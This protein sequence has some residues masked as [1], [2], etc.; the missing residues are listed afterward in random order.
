MRHSCDNRFR[1]LGACG[2]ALQSTPLAGTAPQTGAAR[3]IVVAERGIALKTWLKRI[4][5][6]LLALVAVVAVIAFDF[7]RHGGQFR[8]LTP[9]FAGTCETLPLAASAE[10]IQLDRARGLAYLSW[11]DRR[12]Q[13]EGKPVLG[14][15][16]LVDLNAAEPRPRPALAA[17]PPQFRPHG[18]SLY[19]AGDGTQHLFV[20]SHPPGAAHTVELFEQGPT[21]AFVSVRTVRDPL[22]LDPNAIVAVGPEQFYVANDS[23]ATNPLSRATEL[24][25]R[26]GLSQVV[27]YDGRRM[28]TV[29]GGLK[30]ASGIAMSPDGSRLYVSETSGNSVAVFARNAASGDLTLLERIDVGSAP[31]NINV[32][33]EG[34][35]WIAAHARVLDLGRHFG[36][37]QHLAPTQ[38]FKFTP[39]GKGDARL[40]EVYL[41]AGEQISAGSVGAVYNHKLLIG[42]ITERKL[43]Q[44]HLP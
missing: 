4:G 24:L 20:I 34:N 1:T 39:A 5:L 16:M 12:G 32:D 10:D 9:H 29:A 15:V 11:L 28:R 35:A 37:P 8:T 42:S 13:V 40:A 3:G 41:N 6:A 22:L 27:Y 43:L 38:V 26:R 44:C 2:R 23:G 25:F 33:A 14:T 17:E 18:M 36:D 7:L 30:S 31:D 19:R 21:G